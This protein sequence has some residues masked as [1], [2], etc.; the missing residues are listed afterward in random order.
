[1][2]DDV[3]D[4]WT[5]PVCSLQGNYYHALPGTVKLTVRLAGEVAGI[6]GQQNFVRSAEHHPRPPQALPIWILV[7]DLGVLEDETN[8]PLIGGV[9]SRIT[10]QA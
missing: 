6:V 10:F 1:M 7:V 3:Q 4:D 5:E 9:V 2:E 8:W